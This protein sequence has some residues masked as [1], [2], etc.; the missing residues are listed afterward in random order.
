MGLYAF[1]VFE[2][3]QQPDFF[4]IFFKLQKLLLKATEV[5]TKHQE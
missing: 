5:T 3:A 1:V 4:W 2:V